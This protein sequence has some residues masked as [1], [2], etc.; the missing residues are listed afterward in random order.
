MVTDLD[1]QD[2]G[3]QEQSHDAAT[4]PLA[5]PSRLG[6]RAFLRWLA[7][8]GA[9]LLAAGSVPAASALYARGYD[10][11][12][13]RGVRVAGVALGGLTADAARARL[14]QRVA[15][16]VA[17]SVPVRTADGGH[18]WRITPADLG[19]RLD[20]AGAVAAALRLGRRGGWLD[21]LAARARLLV[22]G[23]ALA[24]AAT[25]DDGRL[26]AALRDWATTATRQPVDARFT[27]DRAGQPVVQ[28]DK[29]GLGLDYNGCRAAF[30]AHAALLSTAPVRLVDAGVTA[31]I[32]AAMLEAIKPQTAALVAQPV[33]LR[34]GGKSWT[35]G[36]DVLRAAFSYRLDGGRLVVALDPTALQPFL[37]ELA[38]AVAD[39]GANARLAL[40][41]QQG[42]YVVTPERA[43]HVLDAAAT[44]AALDTALT[45]G[46]HE[47]AVAL[48]P[49][50]PTIVA[51]DLE[52]ARARAEQIADT[53]LVV[54]YGGYRRVFQR[55]DLLPLLTF[56][57][58]PGQPQKVA[59]GVDPA[60]VHRLT[61]ALAQDINQEPRDAKFKWVNGQVQDAQASQDGHTVEPGPTDAALTAAI[62]G[63]TGA[64]TPQVT[65]TPPAVASSAKAQMSFADRL[66]YGKT[67]YSF[68]IPNRK[69][70][71]ELACQRLN[72]TLVPP[73]AT[74]SFNEAIGVQTIANGYKSGYGIAIVAA[75]GGGPGKVET[76]SSIGGGV[77]QVS[78]TL[79]QGVYHAGLPIEERNWHLYWIEHYG[80]P[81]M[82]LKGLDAT[83][84][85]ESK[86]DFKFQNNTGNWLVVEALT[87]DGFVDISLHGKNPGWK[88]QIDQPVIKDVKPADPKPVYEKTHDLPPG[89]TIQIEAAADGFTAINHIVVT[90]ADGKVIRDKSFMSNY[91]P[92]QNVFQV[93]VP[94]GEPT[95]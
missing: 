16:Y 18:E 70:N 27:W 68:S 82:G 47:A 94:A 4:V 30:L 22:D 5:P 15:A 2:T 63:A 24:L 1:R 74:F 60:G 76:V 95:T 53:P 41:R 52:P 38:A 6:R 57:E 86:V 67:D 79:F 48:D 58:Q 21:N 66:G 92:A 62:L 65:V 7:A 45:A 89:Q 59:I 35:L 28:A 64:A 42:R 3:A 49:T 25:L 37:R 29:P 34:L 91:V 32:T 14:D 78:T 39:P 46:Q 8:G 23:R 11:R 77:C 10:G 36:A 43:G 80:A 73:N 44:V 81:P 51:A 19:V 69:W 61:A 13:F 54:T 40:D 87:Q 83:V 50:T 31:P 71:V 26:A 20:T 56:T 55:A 88:I 90:G 72:G 93:G 9:G 85:S 12:V 17:A 75:Q 84:D 33:T